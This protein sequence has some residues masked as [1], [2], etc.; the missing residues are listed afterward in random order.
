MTAEMSMFDLLLDRLEG[1]G[2][3]NEPADHFE[4]KIH[5]DVMDWPDPCDD[6]LNSILHGSE[7]ETPLLDPLDDMFEELGP[8]V[9]SSAVSDSGMSSELDQQLS[10]IPNTLSPLPASSDTGA[11]DSESSYSADTEIHTKQPQPI[12]TTKTVKTEAATQIR[13]VVRLAPFKATDGNNKTSRSILVPVT[14]QGKTTMRT[15]RIISGAN[16]RLPAGLKLVCA[17]PTTLVKPVQAQTLSS[18]TVESP[19]PV[20]VAASETHSDS[21]S[22]DSDGPRYPRLELTSEEK[23]LLKKEGITL[24]AYYPLTKHEERELKRIRR[25]IRNKISAQDS[26]KRKKEYVD[27]LEER[28]KKCSDENTSLHKKLKALQNQ[29]SVLSTQIRR[30]QALVAQGTSG[31]GRPVQP[32]TC[33]M[34]LLLSLALVVVPNMRP[35]QNSTST[36]VDEATSDLLSGGEKLP[37]VAGRSRTLL[38]N[39]YEDFPSFLADADDEQDELLC[40]VQDHD[41]E[42]PTKVAR[43]LRKTDAVPKDVIEVD[44][45]WPPPK[46]TPPDVVTQHKSVSSSLEVDWGLEERLVGGKLEAVVDEITPNST[47]ETQ[48]VMLKISNGE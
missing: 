3:K 13:R 36:A 28:V 38:F 31:G 34:V 48:T 19:P 44:D 22:D 43:R 45:V 32:A 6:F 17:K 8:S 25:K 40:T 46:K 12:L 30:L 35:N 16:G 42:P 15:F 7:L 1:N 18:T 11:S 26:R 2:V 4:E 14:S 33:L 39:K 20:T 37:P 9:S 27:G 24:P 10:P 21:A 23:R 47:S 41:Y 29:N 5:A